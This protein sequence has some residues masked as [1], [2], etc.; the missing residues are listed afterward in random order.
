[1]TMNW[2]DDGLALDGNAVG[3]LLAELF[4]REMTSVERI[5]ATCGR[6][7]PL[8]RHPAYRGAGIVL[9]CPSCEAV[10]LVVVVQTEE[11]SVCVT[12]V[13]RLSKAP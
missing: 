12:G 13:L 8:G 7:H 5:C 9:R 10:A 1:M 6:S 11:A 4:G 3:G 2:Q